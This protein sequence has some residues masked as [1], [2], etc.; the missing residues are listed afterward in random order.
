MGGGEKKAKNKIK[1]KCKPK[2][3]EEPTPPLSHTSLLLSFSN[4]YAKQQKGKQQDPPNPL[5][6]LLLS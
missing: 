5:H 6:V 3:K 1:N 4:T 2:V